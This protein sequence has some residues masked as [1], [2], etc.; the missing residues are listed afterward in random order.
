MDAASARSWRVLAINALAG[1]GKTTALALLAAGPL[2]GEP[3]NYITF[4]ARAAREARGHFGA[5]TAASTAHSL[6]WHSP[7][8]GAGITMKEV[9]AGRLSSAG[10]Y[11]DLAAAAEADGGLRR[12]FAIAAGALGLGRGW[13]AGVSPVLQV[14]EAFTKSPDP[15]ITAAHV[16]P[17]LR[18]L[19]LR[20][21]EATDLGVLVSEARRLWDRQIDPTSALPISHGV[22]LKLASLS[23]QPFSAGTV[24]FDEAQDASAPMLALLEA[25]VAAGGRLV[26]VGDTFQHIYG[27]AGALNAIEAIAARF[28]D[29]SAVLP[30]CRSY[31]FGEEI[32]D[33]GNAFLG[34]LG[35]RYRLVGDGPSGAVEHQGDTNAVLFRSNARMIME[36]LAN[37][38]HGTGRRIHVV[39]GAKEMVAIL[40]DMGALYKG[41]I[42]T[43]GEL[44]GFADWA[45]L[46]EFTRTPLGSSYAP[47]A[48][49]VERRRGSVGAIAAALRKTEPRM[50][51]SD[52]ILS[53]AH[54]A[55]GGQWRSV[56]LS[57][58]FQGAWKAS[59]RDP[60][61]RVPE[62]EELSL[63][64]VA[65]TRAERLLV[66]RGLIPLVRE[67][68]RELRMSGSDGVSGSAY[69]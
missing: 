26:M 53:T 63:Q 4:N 31:R 62:H 47:L 65:A 49:L 52:T 33:A 60:V 43:G 7:Y 19:A 28:P 14:V 10:L 25:H 6:A 61:P 67:R 15:A 57:E 51:R 16:P 34:A 30:L 37:Q 45:E 36:I 68:L 69:R 42:L 21:Q 38:T 41:R 20:A 1:T 64:Y 5:N 35:A 17:A 29:G 54:K 18:S 12:S 50:E 46:K 23:P 9:F 39:G 59:A 66:H 48:S 55:K 58:E 22:Y 13:R 2:A 44:A 27:W 40:Y 8:P 3:I 24:F 32:A 11:G 56:K